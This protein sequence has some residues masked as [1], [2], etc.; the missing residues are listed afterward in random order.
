MR[1]QKIN[2]PDR[3]RLDASGL[4]VSRD[5][6]CRSGTRAS[7]RSFFFRG[8]EKK[9]SRPVPG[10]SGSHSSSVHSGQRWGIGDPAAARRRMDAAHACYATNRLL[11]CMHCIPCCGQKAS[12][13]WRS[14][15]YSLKSEIE[16]GA[17]ASIHHVACFALL[18]WQ[19]SHTLHAYRRHHAFSVPL[20]GTPIQS[21]RSTGVPGD[22]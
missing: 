19:G 14:K 18:A 6:H 11:E 17:A 22:R 8:G 15:A 3:R 2:A 16:L 1:E 13:R 10:G 5:H 9:I 4:S 20:A 21:G 7:T 12:I